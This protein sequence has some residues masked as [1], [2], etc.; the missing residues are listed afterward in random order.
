MSIYVCMNY[1]NISSVDRGG[2][3]AE[4]GLRELEAG[5]REP[6]IAVPGALAG[7]FPF[8]MASLGVESSSG[9]LGTVKPF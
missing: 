8:S 5:P 4:S 9:S 2:V 3:G 6:G 1:L 7:P